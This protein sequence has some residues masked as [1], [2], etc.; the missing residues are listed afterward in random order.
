MIS[1]VFLGLLLCALFVSAPLYA[2]EKSTKAPQRYLILFQEKNLDAPEIQWFGTQNSPLGVQTGLD[3]GIAVNQ[4]AQVFAKKG[5]S[6]VDVSA[7]QDNLSDPQKRTMPDNRQL[8]ALGRLAKAHYVIFGRAVASASGAVAGSSILSAKAVLSVRVVD[9]ETGE[10]VAGASREGKGLSTNKAAAGAKAI[11]T[12]ANAL[13]DHLVKL[14]NSRGG[15]KA[16]I[17]KKP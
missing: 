5:F 6:V 13:A 2:E 4:F 15:I 17:F 10:I 8:K 9:V 11:K 12:A 1:S 14:M 16:F 7:I 3:L